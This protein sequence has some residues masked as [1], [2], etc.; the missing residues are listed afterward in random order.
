[1]LKQLRAFGLVASASVF[2]AAVVIA[3]DAAQKPPAL[4][5]L[6]RVVSL[7]LAHVR[8]E[9]PVDPD[10]RAQLLQ[11]QQLDV[12]AEHAIATGNYD[13]AQ[14]DLVQANAILGRLGM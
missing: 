3:G 5:S 10:Q 6:E 8:D 14:D 4:A 7:K 12:K 13:A 11:A 9:G 1:M 2:I